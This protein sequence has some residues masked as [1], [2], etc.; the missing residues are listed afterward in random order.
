MAN[1]TDED[2]FLRVEAHLALVPEI[3]TVITDEECE[4]TDDMLPAAMVI[5]G[6]GT[7]SA[8]SRDLWTEEQ[9]IEIGVYFTRLCGDTLEE[10]RAQMLAAYALRNAIPDYFTPLDRLMLNNRPMDG[11]D[12]PTL[13][14][15]SRL[16][17]RPWGENTYYASTYRFT[18]P[19]E[20]R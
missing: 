12:Q 10:Q 2:L 4:L 13:M 1:V 17:T 16:E 6:E 11:I 5:I 15:K 14:T 8:A 20:R 7:S 19:T 9:V 3:V 18:V